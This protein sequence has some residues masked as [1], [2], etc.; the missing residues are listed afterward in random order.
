MNIFVGIAIFLIG[1]LVGYMICMT[2]WI[3]ELCREKNDIDIEIA[4]LK[5]KI[6][7]EDG[8]K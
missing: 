1:C 3:K 7:V 8:N 2:S 6:E 5:A 4:K